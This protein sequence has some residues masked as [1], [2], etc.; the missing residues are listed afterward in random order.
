MKKKLIYFFYLLVISFNA[1]SQTINLEFPYFAG[2][3]Y[4]FTIFQGDKRITLA[5]ATIPKGGKV[6]LTIPVN[7]KGYKGM[8]QW[9]LTNSATGGGLDLIINNEDFSVAC[10]DSI[11]T[12]KS[13]VYQNT[14]ENLFDKVNYKKQQDLFQ[15][16]DAMLATKRAYDPKSKFYKRAAKEYNS[17]IK[18]YTA[19][20][21]ALSTSTFYAAKFR[22]IVNLTMGIG[23]IITLD[24]KEKANN[25]N[26]FITNELSF[27]VLY[28]S[29]HWGGIINSWVQV[30][31]MVIKDDAK[32]IADATTV[33]NRIK[34]D[35]V[36]TDFVVNLTKELTKAGKDDVLFAL[37]MPV[38]NSK[39][40]LNY[41]GV[42]SIYKKD[43]S[44]KAP[45]LV[46][47]TSV[48]NTKDKN[49]ATKVIKT[50]EFHSKYSLLLFYKSGCGPCESTIEGLKTNYATLSAKGLKI[51]AL[52]G[53]TDE[54]EFKTTAA[55][56]PW[57]DTYCDLKGTH[58]ENFKNY[59]VIG[60]P[61]MYLLD[62]KGMIIKK[63]ATVEELMD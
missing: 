6:Q 46:V 50:A 1:N 41:D 52:S 54:A 7:Y 30:Q 49:Q 36:Y 3:T 31:T 55:T 38:K 43:L 15:K 26:N 62:S 28:T 58:G 37:I 63:L 45:D 42:L 14:T 17:I 24:E 40:L 5:Q 39:K 27:E 59:A 22:Q 2:K 56:F 19:Y 20:T 9:Y 23:T 33:I 13:I 25:I 8:A 57:K 44:G 61:T 60:T 18:Q 47:S 10:L 21:N 48:S 11:P 51:I 35:T 4:D 16:H 34:S 29:N 53:D 32:L 12:E